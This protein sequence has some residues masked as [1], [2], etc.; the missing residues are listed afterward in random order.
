MAENKKHLNIKVFGKV[1]GVGFRFN[2]RNVADKL[3]LTGFVRNEP[4][5]SVYIEVEGGEEL[6]G[7]F[8]SWCENGPEFAKVKRIETNE[9]DLKDF[10]SFEVKY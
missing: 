9:E 4:D 3:D 6:L 5:G 10:N 2:T 1:Q 8:V 7:K